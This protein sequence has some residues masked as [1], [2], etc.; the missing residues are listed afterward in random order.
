MLRSAESPRMF[1]IPMSNKIKIFLYYERRLKETC[2]DCYFIS[3]CGFGKEV[4]NNNAVLVASKL[5]NC[6]KP[7]KIE[8]IEGLISKCFYKHLC[9][10]C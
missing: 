9:E 6:Y 4:I 3:S 8:E 2:P 7:Q 1:K 10:G 5:L